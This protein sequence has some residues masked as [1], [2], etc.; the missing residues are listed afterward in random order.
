MNA[1]NRQNRW[2][3]L[4]C[5]LLLAAL[6]AVGAESSKGAAV[7]DVE[8]F[9]STLQRV[10]PDL[11]RRADADGLRA[12]RAQTLA[13]IGE[14]G[15]STEA[16]A[17]LLYLAAGYFKDG[18]TY[19]DWVPQLNDGNT[20]GRCFPLMRLRY[21]NGRFFVAAAKDRSIVG[22]EVV[23]VNGV[24]AMKF[25]A[26]VLD[27]CSGET[28]GF[29]AT[30][31]LHDEPLW[32]YLTNL[33]VAGQQYRLGV[34]GREVELATGSLAEFLALPGP[35]AH[36]TGVEFL[37]G[38]AIALLRYASFG[39]GKAGRERI[40]RIF[41]EIKAKRS[42]DLIVDLRGNW[43]GESRMAEHL[44][45]YL[46][47]GKFR[48][49][50]KVRAKASWDVLRQAPWW[51]RPIM[52]TL[53]GR[54]AGQ[55]LG[56]RQFLKPEAFFSGRSFLLVDNGTFSMA[57]GFAAMF[58]DYKVGPIVGYETGGAAQTFGGPHPFQL[59]H[60]G[61]RCAVSWTEN[62]PP[63]GR[64]GDDVHGVMPDIPVSEDGLA[65]F[66]GEDDPVLSFTVRHVRGK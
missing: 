20:Q 47:D 9:F 55:S 13:G 34:P 58:R 46:Y 28:P 36:G 11:L 15:I 32:Y 25:L 35:V 7:A 16:L 31:F 18:H 14:S 23:S 43:G 30:R 53:I 6:P 44:F 52:L 59:K 56:E 26:P 45:R 61:I 19:V 5:L 12:I 21:G 49:F 3:V 1:D 2:G 65:K 22:Q 24:P 62:F 4:H 41:A 51:A 37:D 60:S 50:R 42:R 63:V 57:S 38:G 29:R 17:S 10:H 54:T 27:R 33:F 40:D 8:Q 64:P 66:L 39:G 48:V